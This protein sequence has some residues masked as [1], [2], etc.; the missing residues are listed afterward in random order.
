M[1][2]REARRPE[3]GNTRAYKVQRTKA[4]DQFAKNPNGSSQLEAACVRAFQEELLFRIRRFFSPL[5]PCFGSLRLFQIAGGHRLAR[6][7][8][9]DRSTS[10]RKELEFLGRVFAILM[11][12]ETERDL[13]LALSAKANHLF[14][15]LI[16]LRV[17]LI[18]YRWQDHLVPLLQNAARLDLVHQAAFAFKSVTHRTSH[19]P[20]YCLLFCVAVKK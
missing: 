19:R 6:M 20:F 2:R 13:R 5:G 3:N 11:S 16:R 18:A 12:L 8:R 10:W 14:K 15:I 1:L 9:T 7:N 17:H 4:L